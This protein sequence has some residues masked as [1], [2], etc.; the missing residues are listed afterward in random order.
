MREGSVWNEFILY[1]DVPLF[2]DGW[3]VEI[4]HNEKPLI[5]SSTNPADVASPKVSA[6][7]EGVASITVA[8]A[9]TP[10]CRITQRIVAASH[11]AY[12]TFETQVEWTESHKLLKV[13]FGA[14]LR[15]SCQATYGTAF[16]ALDRPTCSNSSTDMAMFEV[17]GHNWVDAHQHRRGV[18]LI[19]NCGVYGMSVSG[20]DMFLS[21]LRSP[22]APDANCDM[23]TPQ[24]G[25]R[26]VGAL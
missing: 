15:H 25:I 12:L 6:L 1:D 3:D 11:L 16:G 2:W 24:G 20:S 8:F 5:S 22:K 4:Y 21:L 7:S 14:N 13:H 10:K 19:N 17:C 18:A 23:G 26:S 9:L